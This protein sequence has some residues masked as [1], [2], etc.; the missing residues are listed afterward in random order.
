MICL[1]KAESE[2]SLSQHSYATFLKLLAPFAPHM[3]EE[4]W[5]KLG[6]KESIHAQIW[7]EYDETL[8][9]EATVV[10]AVQIGGKL[11]G[12]LT[13]ERNMAEIAVLEE[14]RQT[15]FYQKYVGTETPKKV[16]FVPN[17]LINIVI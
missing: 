8:L 1:N 16:I 6:E 9:H 12:T 15:D 7:P 3:T 10:I 2:G 14:V 11:R 17:K 5:S 4:L 13:M